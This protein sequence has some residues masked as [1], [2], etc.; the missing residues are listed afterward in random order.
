[1]P[2]E[3]RDHDHPLLRRM[4]AV[5]MPEVRLAPPTALMPAAVQSHLKGMDMFH[6][7]AF[8]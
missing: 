6:W 2:F 7:L 1:M 3:V 8:N 4:G 5:G